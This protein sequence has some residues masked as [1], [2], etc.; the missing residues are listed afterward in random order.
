MKK[1]NATHWRVGLLS[2]LFTVSTLIVAV[3]AQDKTAPPPGFIGE[4]G[5]RGAWPAV[6][7]SRADL[8]THTLY[9]PVTLPAEPLPL[10]IWGNGGCSDN[11]LVH[12]RFRVTSHHMATS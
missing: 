1:V 5:G 12:D 3:T 7:Q 10:L 4:Q 11:G 2:L 9:R 6:A 8:R